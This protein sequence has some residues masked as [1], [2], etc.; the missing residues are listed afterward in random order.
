MFSFSAAKVRRFSYSRQ[1][2]RKKNKKNSLFIDIY[3]KHPLLNSP[4]RAKTVN[5]YLFLQRC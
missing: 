5:P 4:F 2:S 3:Q 1:I